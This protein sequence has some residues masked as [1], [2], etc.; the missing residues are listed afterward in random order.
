LR[1]LLALGAVLVLAQAACG[2]A[3]SSASQSARPI[4]ISSTNT[5]G[6]QSP[7]SGVT[8]AAPVST[9]LTP[10]ATSTAGPS[11]SGSTAAASP[12]ATIA[13][14]QV[15]IA[16]FGFT[17]PTLNVAVGAQVTWTNAGPSNH[18]VTSNNGTFDS[19]PI[20]PNATFNFTFATAGTYAYHCSLHPTIQGSV[21]VS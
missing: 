8:P 13:P 2:G 7:T 15:R 16:D 10:F 12:A 19:G 1:R 14:N 5:P 9:V 11:S 3:S 4:V 18:T 17:P 20:N 6:P 21:V